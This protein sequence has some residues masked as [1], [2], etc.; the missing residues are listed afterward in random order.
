MTIFFPGKFLVVSKIL[1]VSNK[2]DKLYA[3]HDA[4]FE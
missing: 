1:A 3:C 4:S 2:Y